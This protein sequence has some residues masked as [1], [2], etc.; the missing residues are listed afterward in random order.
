MRGDRGADHA[1][2]LAECPGKR[3]ELGHCDPIG[4]ISSLEK[5]I[6]QIKPPSVADL[7]ARIPFLS[8]N[9]PNTSVPSPPGCRFLFEIA[10]AVLGVVCL[11]AIAKG[12][13]AVR[14]GQ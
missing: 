7:T 4:A 11:G 9:S 14:D 3:R 1:G 8:G 13:L 5:A 12:I 2:D 6:E 10:G